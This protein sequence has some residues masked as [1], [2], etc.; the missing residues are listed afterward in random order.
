M[1]KSEI[2]LTTFLALP[3]SFVG[4]PIYLNIA[5]FY[6]QKFQLSLVLIGFL[7]AIIRVFD[8]IQDPLIGRYSDFLCSKK[9]SRKKLISFFASLLCLG[10]F[11]IF[12]PPDY[13]SKNFAIL[14]FFLALTLTYFC[15][16]FVIIN[17]ETA[18]ALSAEKDEQRISLN[19]AKEF[20]GLIGMIFAFTLPE[21]IAKTLGKITDNYFFLSL[22]FIIL[23]LIGLVFLPNQFRNPKSPKITFNFSLI[24][25]DKKFLSFLL[26]FFIN[27]IAVALPAANLNFYVSEVLKANSQT[28]WFL[29][30]YFISACCFIFLWRYL[31]NKI[32]IVKSWKISILGSVFT[33]IFAYFLSSQN[34]NYFYLVCLL[35]G[36]FLGSDLIAV[37]TILSKITAKNSAMAT[38]YFSLWNFLSKIALMIAASGSLIILGFLNYQ[39]GN[40]AI[41]NLDHIRFFYALLPCILKLIVIYLLTKFQKYEN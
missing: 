34:S 18:I 30:T 19:S 8:A 40:S 7:L 20:F 39:P 9:I 37:P 31:F 2:F 23:T 13:L 5:A 17:F 11:L 3:L 41:S 33:F 4:I 16:N 15:F 25:A 6:S 35:S 32:G 38:T 22:I 21:I 24:F 14:W 10:F 26:I 12:N 1:K 36:I 27:S 28:P 29:S